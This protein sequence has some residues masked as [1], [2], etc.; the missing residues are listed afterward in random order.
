MNVPKL[1][2]LSLATWV[3]VSSG[4]A[5]ADTKEDQ[6]YAAAATSAQDDID[7]WRTSIQ[8]IMTGT[9]KTHGE[10]LASIRTIN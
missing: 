2:C 5:W 4:P 6:M 9:G 8:G 3:L 10:M 1:L 7:L